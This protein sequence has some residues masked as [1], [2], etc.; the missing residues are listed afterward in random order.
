MR[1]IIHVHRYVPGE[2]GGTITIGATSRVS[3]VEVNLEGKILFQGPEQPLRG[4][5]NHYFEKLP[6]GNYLAIRDVYMDKP[7]GGHVRGSRIEEW[8][9]SSNNEFSTSMYL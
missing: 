8:D 3:P 9:E 7:E 6:V 1:C 5:V 2:N 4:R